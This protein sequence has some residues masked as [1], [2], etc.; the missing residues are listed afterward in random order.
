MNDLELDQ[1]LKETDSFG[2]PPASF[3]RDVWIRIKA[4]ES[5]GWK[6][7][8]IRHLERFFGVFA[9]PPV[10]VA[11]CTAMIA[12]GVWIGIESADSKA[13]GKVAYVESISP[14]AQTHR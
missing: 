14:F 13:D 9:L 5:S 3:Q 1:L 4:T 2:I 8:A 12:L 11:T 6:P 10:A 7:R